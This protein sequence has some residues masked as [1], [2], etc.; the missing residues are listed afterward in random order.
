[1]N[2]CSILDVPMDVWGWFGDAVFSAKLQQTCTALRR[3]PPL[4]PYRDA[5]YNYNFGKY[6]KV[7]RGGSVILSRGRV[8][9]RGYSLNPTT[10]EMAKTGWIV[11]GG[12]DSIWDCSAELYRHLRKCL[13][14]I[15]APAIWN[16]IV[17]GDGSDPRIVTKWLDEST[18]KSHTYYVEYVC[19]LNVCAEIITHGR[20]SVD[21][22]P[23]EWIKRG[24][25][26]ALYL[27]PC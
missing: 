8:I 4:E 22:S 14:R 16:V 5:D 20:V 9:A 17:V 2:V 23:K 18:A 27:D 13:Y 12:P 21:V 25:P 11:V 24:G 10:S 3:T 15:S 6:T 19:V 26:R 1:M 7:D